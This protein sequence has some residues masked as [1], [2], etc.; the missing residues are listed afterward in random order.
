MVL[1]C[2]VDMTCHSNTV[3]LDDL[4]LPLS[5]DQGDQTIKPVSDK[6]PA[7][8]ISYETSSV[9]VPQAG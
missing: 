6:P 3:K 9:R 4:I 8:D 1:Q 5:S 2:F 7:N